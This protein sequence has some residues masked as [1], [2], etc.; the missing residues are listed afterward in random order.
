[1]S[2]IQI[3]ILLVLELAPS[4]IYHDILPVSTRAIYVSVDMY[5][6]SQCDSCDTLLV[7]I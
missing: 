6:Y 3:Y 4:R 2:A 5:I 7:K 1:M